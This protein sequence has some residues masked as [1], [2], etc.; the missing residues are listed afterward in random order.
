[1]PWRQG[2]AAAVVWLPWLLL[3]EQVTMKRLQQLPLA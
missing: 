1:L 2:L 3:A